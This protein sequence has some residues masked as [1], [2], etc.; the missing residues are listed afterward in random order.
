MHIIGKYTVI[1]ELG[2]GGFGAVYL[3]EDPKLGTKVAIKV[4][5]V[6]DENLAGI[7]TSASQDAGGALKDR[8]LSEARTLVSLSHNPYIV[9]LMEFDEMP[10]GT[11]YYVMPY[12][13]TS[14]E[15]EIGKDAFSRGKLEEPP[16]PQSTSPPQDCQHQSP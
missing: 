3:A 9:N 12:L 16:D 2:A 13:P 15:Q 6:K 11:P 4:F 7:A 5:R 14:L 8:F 1:K 10:D